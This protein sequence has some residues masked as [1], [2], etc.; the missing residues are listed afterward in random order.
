MPSS[1]C[2]IAVSFPIG[3]E[4]NLSKIPD[5]KYHPTT[6]KG[7]PYPTNSANFLE[8]NIISKTG[9]E[10][11]LYINDKELAHFYMSVVIL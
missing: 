5:N 11:L 9:F 3:G 1:L 6:I 10:K 7:P 4:I 2:S 8:N